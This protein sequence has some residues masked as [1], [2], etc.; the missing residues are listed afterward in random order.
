MCIV[1]AGAPPAGQAVLV[2]M[3]TSNST[4]IQ[5]EVIELLPRTPAAE[6]RYAEVDARRDA[7]VSWTRAVVHARVALWKCWGRPVV[8]QGHADECAD[9]RRRTLIRT[10]NGSGPNQVGVVSA[11]RFTQSPTI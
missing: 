8:D 1:A 3:A 9:A 7:A 5:D 6:T 10:L 2:V 11:R 4:L